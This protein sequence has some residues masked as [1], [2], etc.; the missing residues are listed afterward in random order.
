MKKILHYLSKIFK[1]FE[2]Y[3]FLNGLQIILKFL[4]PIDKKINLKN[5]HSPI[6][7]RNIVTDKGIFHQVFVELE[8]DYPFN[9]DKNPVIIDAGGNIGLF[10]IFFKNKFPDSQI[11]IIEPDSDNFKVSKLNLESYSNIFYENSGLWNR[12][13]KIKVYDKYNF[14][15]SGLVV[16]EDDKYG[17]LDAV[18]IPYLM[19]K[20]NLNKIEIVKLDIETSEI[21]LFQENYTDWILNTKYIVIELHDRIKN[22]CG[23]SFFNA[24]QSTLKNYRFEI[25][26]ENI[27]IENLNFKS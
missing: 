26:G 25:R 13:T 10:S 11:I 22:G 1:I 21:E 8:Y 23:M 16:E 17:N 27:I 3:G 6:Y 24:I 7:L 18:S 12:K 14:G 2:N 19:E 20:Y 4:L 9:L 5:I 15:K